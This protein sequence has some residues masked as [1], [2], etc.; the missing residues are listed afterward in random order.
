MLGGE[1][2]AGGDSGDDKA[3]RGWALEIAPEGVDGGEDGAGGGHV[4]GDVGAEGQ[5][6][7][8]EAEEGES[9]EAGT[10]VE[11]LASGEEDEQRGG[12][13][14]EEGWKASAEDESISS[15]VAA[16]GG[17]VVE[18]KLVAVEVGFGFEEAVLQGWDVEMEGKER[19]SGQE[20]DHRRVL[21]IEAEVVG[22]PALV[23][24]EDVIVFVPGEGLAVDGVDDLCGED[25][26]QSDD[27]GGDPAVGASGCGSGF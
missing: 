25:E 1:G 4:G 15:V 16:V 21:G 26:E 6:V 12:Y 14:E 24:G 7:G 17:T 10:D 22:L 18:E 11:H 27:R 2:E 19:E 20:F 8:I 23:A 5:Q 3:R 13:G 9:D